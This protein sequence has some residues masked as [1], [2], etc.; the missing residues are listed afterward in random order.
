MS[1]KLSVLMAASSLV[2]LSMLLVVCAGFNLDPLVSVVKTGAHRSLFG[3][4]VALHQ[5]LGTGGF[6]LL[7]GA[8]MERAELGIL[9]NRTGGLYVCPISSD[10]SDCS[11]VKVINSEQILSED[12]IEDMWLGVSVASQGPPGGRVLTCGH[13][14]AKVYGAYRL[15]HMTGRCF[16]RGNDLQYNDSDAHW[17]NPDQVCSHLGDVSGEVMCTMGISAAISQTEIVVGSPGSFDWQGNVHV[18]WMNPE[19]MFDTKRNTFRNMEQRNIYIGYSV[20]LAPR[21]LSQQLD[22]IVTGAPKD[23]KRDARG[24]VFLALKSGAGLQILQ[25]LRGEQMGSYYGSA[26]AVV[27]LNN[28]GWNDLLIGAPFFFQ[29]QQEVGGAVYMYLNTGGRFNSRPTLVLKGPQHS[30]FGMALCAAGDLDQD[31]FQDFVVGA[32]FHGTGSVMIFNSGPSGVPP[33][34]SQVIQ[35]RSISPL[36]RTFGFSLASAQDVDR[37]QHPDLLVGSLDDTVVLLRSRPVVE[38]TQTLQVSPDL[39]D[40]LDCES[41]IRVKVCFSY[42][43]RTGGN[44]DKDNITVQFSVSADVFSLKPR[45]GFTSSGQSQVWSSL[46]MPRVHCT[47]LRAGLLIPIR[48]QV[49][50]LVFSLNA[51][52]VQKLHKKRNGMQD[53]RRF[54]VISCPPPPVR[55][56]IHIQKSCGN[57]NRCHSNLQMTAQ[58]TDETHRPLDTMSKGHQRLVLDSSLNLLL[59]HVNVTNLPLPWKPFNHTHNVSSPWRPIDNTYNVLSPWRPAEDAHN[60]ALNV[61]IPRSLV[62]SGVRV[63]GAVQ[64]VECAVV[65]GALL[66]DL[67]NPLKANQQVEVWIRFQPSEA[68]LRSRE[69]TSQLQLSTLSE[70]WD[71]FPLTVSMWVE[72]SLQASLTL[73]NAPGPIY[74]SGHVR[75]ESAI[76]KT[77]DIGSLVMFHFQVHKNGWS[78]HHLGNLMLV[79]DWPLEL[80]SGKWLLYL[81]HIEIP[82]TPAKLCSPSAALNPLRLMISDEEEVRRKKHNQEQEEKETTTPARILQPPRSTSHT[83]TCELGARCPRVECPLTDINNTVSITV[84]AHLWNSTFLEDFMDAHSVTIVGRATLQLQ[85]DQPSVNMKPQ[86]VQFSVTVFPDL[87]LPVGSNAPLGVLLLSAVGGVLLLALICLLLWKCGFFDRHGP[88]P[89]TLHQGTVSTRAARHSCTDAD[90]FL[91]EHC[92]PVAKNSER[93][94]H[95]V[96]TF[97]Q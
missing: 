86:S 54:P 68:S 42:N 33:Q 35:G 29:R 76:K 57:D 73:L 14:F 75:G 13:R 23:S 24:S 52:I 44:S 85:T 60:V 72:V 64:A 46:M 53:L 63:K 15:R 88:W 37:N 90:G 59:L 61:T 4:S 79:F 48:D 32:P 82:G 2:L 58:F 16:V 56:L 78:L 17:Q 83:L 94:K 8:P 67:G 50:P 31:G 92:P 10:P 96:T 12:L 26:L 30:A 38:L 62:Y 74:F 93:K 69:I 39:V 21:L 66:C 40:P 18:L 6:R 77:S 91:I 20:A 36:F 55:H 22:S 11:R 80:L 27:D 9:A 81:R 71:L 97:S 70:Q 41:C 95:L 7:V 19:V 51:S 49:Q 43:F 34:P 3:F 87:S 89:A 25:R 1:G 47:T 5:D 28:D 84:R 65:G 45:I